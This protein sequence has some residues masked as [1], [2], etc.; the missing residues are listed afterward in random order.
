MIQSN[1][2][3]KNQFLYPR[4]SYRGQVTPENLIFNANLQEFSHKV[5]YITGLETSGKLSPEEA[6]SQI[7][8]LWK[9]LKHS[10]KN[11]GID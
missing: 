10:K 2:S 4:S 6:Y 7:Q 3:D 9:Q 5:G 1:V 11:L 8:V